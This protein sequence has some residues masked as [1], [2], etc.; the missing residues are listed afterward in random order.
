MVNY[1]QARQILQRLLASFTT[2]ECGSHY[3]KTLTKPKAETQQWL[4]F[5]LFGWLRSRKGFGI[6][7]AL[8]EPSSGRTALGSRATFAP[9]AR[10]AEGYRMRRLDAAGKKIEDF[11][12]RMDE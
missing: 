7:L 2:T 10:L 6:R 3:Q 9:P 1:L 5:A 8:F 12:S 4:P 11:H